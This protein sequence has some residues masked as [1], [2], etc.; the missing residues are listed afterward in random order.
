M[1][2]GPIRKNVQAEFGFLTV[3]SSHINS[4]FMVFQVPVRLG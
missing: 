1:W 2:V 4:M 3:N